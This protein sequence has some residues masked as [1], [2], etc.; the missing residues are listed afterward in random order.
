MGGDRLK[1]RHMSIDKTSKQYNRRKSTERQGSEQTNR[2]IKSTRLKI[3]MIEIVKRPKM[4][5]N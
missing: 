5:I 1:D 3:K 2:Y 4:K